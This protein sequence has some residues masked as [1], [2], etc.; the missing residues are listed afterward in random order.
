M[1][2]R[3]A[4]KDQQ[5][6][7][8]PVRIIEVIQRSTAYLEERGVASARLQVE[9]ILAQLLGIPRL[10]LYLQFD[11]ILGP[12]TLD[13]LRDSIRRRGQRVPLQHLL[14]STEFCGL[15]LESSPDALI[16]RP[17]TESLAERAWS[18]LSALLPDSPGPRAPLVLDWGTGSG[19]LA[20]AIA[21]HAPNVRLVAIDVSPAA[22]ALAR[23]NAAR[24]GCIDR[25]EFIPSDGCLALPPE[26]RFDLVVANPPYIPSQEIAHLE[27]EVRDHDPLLALDGGPDG[28]HCYRRLARELPGRLEPSGA[29]LLEHGDGQSQSIQ[30]VFHDAGWTVDPP[31]LD[32][33]QRDRFLLARLA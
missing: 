33:N 4:P 1:Q 22:L 9:W 13:P 20:I 24:H 8:G 3:F 26:M 10:Q 31:L 12:E 15:T 30:R 25:I 32:F 5:V 16:P 21:V 7:L 2:V 28:L 6:L 23:R 17:E 14:G 11:R 19:C 29:L 18:C 27:P